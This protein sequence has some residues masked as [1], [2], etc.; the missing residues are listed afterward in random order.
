MICIVVVRIARGY[1]MALGGA[2]GILNL[3]G[4]LEGC[5]NAFSLVAT[6]DEGELAVFT[7]PIMVV[8]GVFDQA[9]FSP[10]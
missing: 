8:F 2:P 7:D 6:S 5:G 10:I 4:V 3:N 9:R 1:W